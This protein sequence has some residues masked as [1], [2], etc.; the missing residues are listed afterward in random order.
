MKITRSLRISPSSIELFSNCSMQYKWNVIDEIEPE[1]GSDNLYAIL[2]SAL[3]KSAQLHFKYNLTYE[4][5]RNYWKM[6][7]LS[8]LC[9]AKYLIEQHDEINQ[10]ISKGYDL[11]K[12]IFKIK[13][14]WKDAKII[15]TEKYYRFPY[16][17]SFIE[18]VFL[19]GKIDLVI[20]LKNKVY[21]AIDW[22]SS[23]TK[24]SD[25]DNDL[26]MTFYIY[27]IHLHYNI[28]YENIW[29]ALVY[30]F[31]QDILFT[32]RE[33]KD[34]LVKLFKKVDIMLERIAENDF[35]KEPK[36]NNKINK[37]YFCSY[38]RTCEK[39]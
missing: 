37:C 28:P 11:L 27:F 17:N 8:H 16:D 33:E 20:E 15:D 36:I 14:R 34:I 30:P 26:Q 2:G 39:L 31:S 9:D 18:N 21:T 6:L 4:E 10:F 22:K 35:K 24:N 29:A 23:K 12:S 3:H 13:E 32:Q 38:K 5:L 19:S 25:I 1:L 7:F